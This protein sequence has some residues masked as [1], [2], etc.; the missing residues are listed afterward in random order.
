[1]Y[2]TRGVKGKFAQDTY[3]QRARMFGNRNGYKEQFQLWITNVLMADWSRCFIFHKLAIQSARL[4]GTPV[5]LSDNKTIPTS[6]SSIDRS[7]V[8]IEDGEMSF[9]LFNYDG[10]IEFMGD[11]SMPNTK[12]LKH[13][14]AT[15][16]KDC[17][18]DYI[19]HYILSDATTEDDVCFHKASQFG[20]DKSGYPKEEIDNIRR[21][22]GIFSYNEFSR[23][24]K[25]NARHH[26]K[27]YFNSTGKAR[28]FYKVNGT[29]IKFIQNKK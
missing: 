6:P 3:I 4:G 9:K 11:K 27:I 21:I 19:L 13:L 29:A 24:D 17:F 10:K 8:D 2:F 26:L 23:G 18:P 20:T 16:P 28:L 15:L 25:P 14:Q 22:K 1:M 5:W 7:S 12:R